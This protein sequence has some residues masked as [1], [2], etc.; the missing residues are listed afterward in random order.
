MKDYL[1][2]SIKLLLACLAYF[3]DI[4]NL[5][6]AVLFFMAI[7]WLTG[8]YAS[9]KLREKGKSWFTSFK[10]RRTIEKFVFYMLAIAVAYVFRQ[11]FFEDLMLGKI[12][13]GYIALT[14]MKSIYENISRI[15]GVNVFNEIWIVIKNQF[16]RKFN[17]DEN[18]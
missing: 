2:F 18:H 1:S 6:H 16:N 4:K 15:M 13:A 9:Y 10:M 7:D 11:E 5:F 17:I 14:E 8:V 3:S 12:V